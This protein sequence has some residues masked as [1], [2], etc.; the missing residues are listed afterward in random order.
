MSQLSNLVN[1]EVSNALS[2]DGFDAPTLAL[3]VW[4][5]LDNKSRRTC[6]VAE[7]IRR[8]KRAAVNLTKDTFKISG[9]QQIELPFEIDGAVSID[10]DVRK[11]RLTE[12]LSQIEFA[13]AIE[14]RREQIRHDRIALEA[15]ETAAKSV[16]P[17]WQSHPDWTFGQCVKALSEGSIKKTRSAA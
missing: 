2:S 3:K 7:L 12:S 13:R 14:I 17:Y 11:I 9:S 8:M 4:E 6:G 16:S 1:Q 10:L 5:K 15:W